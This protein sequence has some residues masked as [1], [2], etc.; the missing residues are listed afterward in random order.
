MHATTQFYFGADIILCHADISLSL[1][2]HGGACTLR[3]VRTELLPPTSGRTV[4]PHST[5]MTANTGNSHG[6]QHAD[7]RSKKKKMTN[8]LAAVRASVPPPHSRPGVFSARRAAV[9]KRRKLE[10]G[11]T[12]FCVLGFFPELVT[13]CGMDG[14][15][16]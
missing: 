9:L 4:C 1:L 15:P 2:C 11:L 13:S 3:L 6:R 5:F 7:R 10:G 12:F 14:G 8:G 16:T